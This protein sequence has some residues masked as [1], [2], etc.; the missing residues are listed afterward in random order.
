LTSLGKIL[1]YSFPKKLLHR[2]SENKYTKED[3][4]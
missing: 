2:C 3:I 4:I 1:I